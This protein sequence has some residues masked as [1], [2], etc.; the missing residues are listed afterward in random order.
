MASYC[1]RGG[2]FLASGG[3]HLV[4]VFGGCGLRASAGMRC[5]LFISC[6]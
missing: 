2:E 4:N 1:S 5:A 3:G 6:R